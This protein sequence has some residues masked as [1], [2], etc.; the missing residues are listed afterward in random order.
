MVIVMD[1]VLGVGYKDGFSD[2]W[3]VG[4]WGTKVAFVIDRVLMGH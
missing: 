2:V 4:A 3:N 1:A